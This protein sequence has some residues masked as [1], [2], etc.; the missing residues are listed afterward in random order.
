VDA[1]CGKRVW[2]RTLTHTHKELVG[3][4]EREEKRQTHKQ[5]ERATK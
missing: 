5:E 4:G 2:I 3:K 1:R